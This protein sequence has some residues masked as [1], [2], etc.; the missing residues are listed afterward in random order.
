MYWEVVVRIPLA[1]LPWDPLCFKGLITNTPGTWP[2]HSQLLGTNPASIKG[3]QM[4]KC[5]VSRLRS[6][7][8][9]RAT[10]VMASRKASTLSFPPRFWSTL[11]S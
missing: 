6:D 4:P 2:R 9:Q 7:S 8:Q 10:L 5:Q 1:I 3:L 11:Y